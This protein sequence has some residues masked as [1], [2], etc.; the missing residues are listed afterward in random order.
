MNGVLLFAVQEDIVNFSKPKVNYIELAEYC[1]TQVDK[2]LDVPVS[3]VTNISINSKKFDKVIKCNLHSRQTKKIAGEKIL[4]LN[5]DRCKSW[6]FTPYKNT[7]VLDTDFIVKNNTLKNVF[8]CSN[9]LL[10]NKTYVDINDRSDNTVERLVP[11]GIDMYWATVFYFTKNKKTKTFFDLV[12]HIQNNWYYYR[13]L[14]SI[15]NRKFRND[16]AFSI[17]IHILSGYTSTDWPCEL[18]DPL[19]SSFDN[20]QV[21]NIDNLQGDFLVNTKNMNT[22]IMNKVALTELL[23]A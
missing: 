17:A 11:H 18:P 14:Y 4:W 7:L 19:I 16:F 8:D 22:H 2:H 1:A 3:L 20:D 5:F 21:Y 6:K 12:E 15:S 10:I 9:D 23:N 13:M